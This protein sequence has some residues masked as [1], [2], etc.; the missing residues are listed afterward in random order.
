MTQLS[1]DN[2]TS[3]SLGV[4]MGYMLVAKQKGGAMD[5]QQANEFVDTLLDIVVE[6]A[7]ETAWRATLWFV[8][9]QGIM[10]TATLFLWKAAGL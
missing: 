5:E 6:A 8:V 10:L 7:W 2:L 1:I 3:L 9:F 4:I